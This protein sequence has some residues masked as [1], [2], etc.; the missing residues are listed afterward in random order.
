[1]QVASGDSGV[2]Q[3]RDSGSLGAE[4]RWTV[5]SMESALAAVCAGLGIAWL[6]LHRIGPLLQDGHLLPLP[7]REGARF[8]TAL[9]LVY[10]Q[11]ERRG[12]GVRQLTELLR[13]AVERGA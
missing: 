12:R 9:Y 8:Q 2:H 5:S 6:P 3:Q 13:G 11:G 10:G 4:H 7:R 1:M